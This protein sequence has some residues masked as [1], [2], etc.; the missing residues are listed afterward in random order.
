MGYLHRR[1]PVLATLVIAAAQLPAMARM[2]DAVLEGH[3]SHGEAFNEGPR[4]AAYLMP[5]LGNVHFPVTAAH[6]SVQAFFD[7]GVGQLHGFWYFEAERTFRQVAALDPDCA[8]AYWGMAMANVDNSERAA[9]FARVAWLKRGLVT[10]RERA[11]ID[12]VARFHEVEGPAERRPAEDQSAQEG[13]AGEKKDEDCLDEDERKALKAERKKRGEQLIKDYEEIVWDYPDD[14]EAKAFLVNRAWLNRRL[15]SPISSR[16][17]NEA[18]LQQIFAVE[19]EHPA[20]H[21]RIHLWDAKDQAARVVDSANRSGPSSPGIAHMWHMGGHIFA[22][23]GRHSDAAWQQEAS[24]RVDHGQMI[25]D[26]LIP[27]QISNY[28]HNNEWL[29]RSMRHH[30][31]VREAVAL[32]KNMIE[33]PR[34]PE[35]NRLDKDY[36][37]ATFG[38]RRLLETLELYEQWEELIALAG[39]MYLEPS[40]QAT[41]RAQRAFL[42]GKAHAYLGDEAGFDAQ[43]EALAAL[44]DEARSKRTEDLERAEDEALADEP[45]PGDLIEVMEGVLTE[46]QDELAELRDQHA[47]LPLLW[48]VLRAPFPDE[49]FEENIE[50][51]AEFGFEKAHLAEICLSAGLLER[52]L[53]LARESTEERDGRIY[54]HATLAHVLHVTGE[55]EEALDVFDELR[56]WSARADLDM[57]V[58]KRLDALARARSLPADWRVPDEAAPDV[59]GRRSL[60]DLGPLHWTPPRAPD[61]T[62]PDGFGNEISLSDYAGQPVLVIFFL[63]F[64]CVHCVEQLNA[65]APRAEAFADAG[66][67][68]VAIGTNTAEQ[69]AASLDSPVMPGDDVAQAAAEHGFPFPILSDADLDVFKRYRAHDDFENEALHGTFLV[70]AKGRIRWQDIS[71]EPFMDWEFLLDES[72]RQL[73]LS[74]EVNTDPDS[75]R[76]ATATSAGTRQASRQNPAD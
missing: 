19:P 13:E 73:R 14:I 71:Y 24:A 54:F 49:G 66:I 5:S 25:R 11:Y 26:Q 58:F 57:P 75:A 28:A 40:D 10:E 65:F 22:R 12:A 23:L 16:Q 53:E 59:A 6:D 67:Q 74:D 76:K 27:D 56:T 34:H 64:K 37:S 9:S 18:I 29:T 50:Q 68:I 15:G 20:H 30:G 43:L 51:L 42:L 61:W 4:Q 60:E 62:C 35:Y 8:M 45:E 21:Y 36:C 52:A 2:Q 3:S 69:F 7:Q 41:D 44:V 47:S 46:H 33:L 32:A 1:S 72:N 17:A 31:R 39:S 38:R 48:K 70:D 55:S 63:G